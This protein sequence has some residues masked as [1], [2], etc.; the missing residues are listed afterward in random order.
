MPEGYAIIP[1]IVPAKSRLSAKVL[2]TAAGEPVALTDSDRLLMLRELFDWRVN[3]VIV[4]PMVNEQWEIQ[5]FTSLLSREPQQSDGVY[6]WYGVDAATLS[7]SSNKA[8][9]PTFGSQSLF[10]GY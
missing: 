9:P 2:A 4:G 5:L 8:S 1:E 7:E 10:R 3:T 6:I